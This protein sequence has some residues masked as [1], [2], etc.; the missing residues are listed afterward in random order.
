VTAATAFAQGNRRTN[1]VVSGFPLTVAS[2]TVT[3]FDNGFILFG[4]TSFTVDLRTN[5]GG[6][7]FS[8]RV[9][10]V[11]VRCGTPC[12]TTFA[13]VQ[14]RTA[15][16]PTW[17]SLNNVAFQTIESRTATF[18]GTNDPWS[19]TVEWRHQLLW[20]STPPVVSRQIAIDFQLVVTAP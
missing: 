1:I 8:P 20:A 10:T 12:P 19:R 14:W 17:Q 7:G 9:T 6:G 15:A 11:Q 16:Q 2:T 5:T 18:N 4:S 3:D 13:Q